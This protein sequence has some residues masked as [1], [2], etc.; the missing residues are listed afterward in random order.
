MRDLAEISERCRNE[1]TRVFPSKCLV[2][3][4][5][6]IVKQC[7]DK[8]V[9]HV[10]AADAPFEL[11]KSYAGEL[12]HQ[13]VQKVAKRLV[14]VDIDVAAVGALS[15][16][17]INDILCADICKDDILPGE[18]FDVILCCD[19]IEHVI[20]PGALLSACRRFMRDNSR[21]SVTTINAT[22]LKPALRALAGRESVHPDH[23]AYYS[24]A[25]LSRLLTLCGFDPYEFGVFAYPT[26]NP[27]AGWLS[28]GIMRVAPG[29]AD[30]IIINA[31]RS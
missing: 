6:S 7:R 5:D 18:T 20:A 21:L 12:L 10:G 22:A 15:K 29:T 11:E 9:L 16:L 2:N 31:R 13:K 8:T 19:V 4:D 23:V 1:W 30:G 14:G 17:G 3:R 27:V 26:I 28:R 24:F 25:T